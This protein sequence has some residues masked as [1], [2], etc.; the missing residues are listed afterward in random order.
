MI[1]FNNSKLQYLIIVLLLQTFLLLLFTI[2]ESLDIF[3]LSHEIFLRVILFVVI[4]LSILS[5]LMV[6]EAFK[7]MKYEVEYKLQK[8]K[9]KEQ[10][11][12]IKSL[13]SQKHDFLNHLQTIFGMLQMEKEN[14]VKSYISSLDKDLNE[15]SFANTELSDSILDCI[16]VPKEF[17]AIQTEIEFEQQVEEGVE[18]IELSLDKVFRIVGNLVDNAIEATAS[19]KGEK[20]IEIEGKDKGAEYLL[21]VYNSGPIIEKEELKSILEPGFSTKGE[22]RGFGLYIIKTLIEDAGGKLKVKSEKDYGTEFCCF[23]PKEINDC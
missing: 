10:E 14:Q 21:R 12:L 19:F 6:K 13:K 15:I 1:K 16:L 20:K 5:V 7:L 2:W 11:K 22:G 4:G 23:L 17:E 3:N 9:V 8:L 18:Q